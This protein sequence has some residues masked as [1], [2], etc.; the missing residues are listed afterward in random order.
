MNEVLRAVN[1]PSL[2]FSSNTSSSSAKQ[3]V[4]EY[5]KENPGRSTR[6]AVADLGVSQTA[7]QNARKSGEH[8]CSPVT[9]PPKEEDF[10]WQDDS[11]IIVE[12][13]LPI[14]VYFNKR[15]ELVIRQEQEDDYDAFIFIALQNIGEFIDKLTDIVGIPSVGKL[16]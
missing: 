12:K 3:R 8:G 7:V 15:N 9:R 16:S 11:S 10:N 4:A 1:A 14:A 2:D 13:Q 5:D 6:Q